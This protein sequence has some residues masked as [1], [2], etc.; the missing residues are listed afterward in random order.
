LNLYHGKP[1]VW[2]WS[3][4]VLGCSRGA[5]CTA[6]CALGPFYS[7]KAAR[8]RWSSI[9][10]AIVAFCPWAHQT[11]RC[12]TGQWTVCDFLP[13]LAKP[14]VAAT[15]LVAHQTVWCD[16]LTVGD[17]HMLSTDRATDRWRRRP[18][19]TPDGPVNYTHDFSNFFREQPV[20]LAHQP[21]HRTLSDAQRTVRCDRRLVQVW[22]GVAKLLQSNLFWFDKVPST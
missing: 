17:L 5:W 4:G 2:M 7:P 1:D 19:A 18:A 14:T 11:V 10:K 16:L 6:P 3:L 9:W 13:F 8:S 15:T 21:E 20:H 22:L 12:T